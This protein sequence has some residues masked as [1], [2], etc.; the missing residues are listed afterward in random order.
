MTFD[1]VSGMPDKPCQKCGCTTFFILKNVRATS[2]YCVETKKQT[3]TVI[4]KANEKII[5]AYCVKCHAV[6]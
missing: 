6:I 5:E 3:R 2:E 1:D 4:D